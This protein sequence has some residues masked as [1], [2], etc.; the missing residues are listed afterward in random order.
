[1]DNLKKISIIDDD[2]ISTYLTQRIVNSSSFVIDSETFHQSEKALLCIKKAFYEQTD[3]PDL[4][5]LDIN[6]PVHDGWDFI[7]ELQKT[8]NYKPIPIVVLSSSIYKEDKAKSEMYSEIKGYFSKPLTV[9]K[10]D[11]IMQQVFNVA[12]DVA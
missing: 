7:N 8:P 3:L 10:F 5:L 12:A 6:M 11:E 2:K 4:I 9:V 1:M